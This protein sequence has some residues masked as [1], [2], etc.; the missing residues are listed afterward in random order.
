[1]KRAATKIWFRIAKFVAGAFAVSLVVAAIVFFFVLPEYLAARLNPITNKPPYLVSEKAQNLHRQLFVAD[2]HADSLLWNRNLLEKSRGGHVDI[3]RMLEG[4]LALQFFTV[5]TKSPNNLNLDSNAGDTDDIF[6]L[7]LA[8]RQPLETLTSLTAR[9]ANQAAH[10]HRIAAA[11]NGKFVVIKSK[12]DLQN[13]LERRRTETDLV[14]GVLGIEGAH[15]L[16]GK[17]ENTEFLFDAGFRMMSPAHFFDSEMSGSMHGVQKGGLTEKGREM[18]K[19]MEARGMLFDLAHASAQTIE[20]VLTIATKPVLVS[21]T[22]VRA[23]CDTNRNLTDDQIRRIARTGGVIGIGFWDTAVCGSDAAAIARAIRHT[24]N[25]IG[26]A[27]VALGSDF[28]GTVET[29]FD[30]SGMALVT[31]ALL[32]ENFSETE[33]RQIMGENVLRVLAENLPD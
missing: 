12:L 33:I 19:K 27:H 23:T 31:E 10:L 6:W 24:A 28:D 4:N 1:M 20:D 5:V 8:Q 26:T 30:A 25:T 18:L 29:P 9:A 32:N 11:S 2:L 22:G 3:P 14:A 16:D 15:A 21:H 7:T 13:F 17:L